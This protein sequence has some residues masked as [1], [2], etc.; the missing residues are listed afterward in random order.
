MADFDPDMPT[1]MQL[2]ETQVDHASLSD[3]AELLRFH[4]RLNHLS[5]RKLQ[6]LAKLG[7]IPRKLGKVK[8]PVCNCCQFRK[9]TCK[10]WRT[11][12]QTSILSTATSPEQIGS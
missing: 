1:E 3:Q 11:K 5:F 4:Y 2:P 12:G 8:R 9:K 7:F 6:S 10:P